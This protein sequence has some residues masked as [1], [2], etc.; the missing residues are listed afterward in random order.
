[1]PL[2]FP[3]ENTLPAGPALS[4][5]PLLQTAAALL[6]VVVL[7]GGL[8]WLL[9]KQRE[10][11]QRTCG[12]FTLIA[13]LSLGQREKIV[14]L[15][16]PDCQLLLGVTAQQITLLHKLPAVESASGSARAP[17]AD[18]PFAEKL[19]VLLDKRALHK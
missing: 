19:R 13:S 5:M 12:R 9:K 17:A 11:Q 14:L 1:M 3:P 10:L 8:G 6:L 4:A 15:A 7:L 2:T 16:L 18:T